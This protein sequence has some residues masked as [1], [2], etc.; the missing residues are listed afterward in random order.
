[1]VTGVGLDGERRFLVAERAH[2]E[3]WVRLSL[4]E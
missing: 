3:L 2:D 1:V 4:H